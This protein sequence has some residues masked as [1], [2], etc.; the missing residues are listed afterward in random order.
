MSGKKGP[1]IE[2]IFHVPSSTKR[3][4]P[5]KPTFLSKMLASAVKDQDDDV[6]DLS[7]DLTGGAPAGPVR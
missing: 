4:K 2:D 7:C 5:Q 6:L 1:P 3:A